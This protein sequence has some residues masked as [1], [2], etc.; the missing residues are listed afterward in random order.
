M[1]DEHYHALLKAF[2]RNKITLKHRCSYANYKCVILDVLH[3]QN[4]TECILLHN[5]HLIHF[6]ESWNL[7]YS[8]V[9]S[10]P[11]PIKVITINKSKRK[12]SKAY[13]LALVERI[14]KY[15]F[16]HH[17]R[18]YKNWYAIKHKVSKNYP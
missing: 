4:D 1:K 10:R 7:L 6:L 8:T 11:V 12:F 3:L 17:I 15:N 9:D 5:R 2:Q 18:Y 14:Y 13:T 16:T